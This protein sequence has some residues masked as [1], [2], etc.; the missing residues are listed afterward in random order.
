M[1]KEK[2][3]TQ[4]GEA[5]KVLGD[6][7]AGL[8]TEK[9]TEA[10]NIPKTQAEA[11]AKEKAVDGKYYLPGLS[12][13][14][15]ATLLTQEKAVK[16]KSLD[17]ARE[18]RAIRS[19]KLWAKIKDNEGN[20]KYA[21]FPQY[22]D[23]RLGFSKVQV[24]HLT[25]WLAKMETLADMRNRDIDVPESLSASAVEGLYGLDRISGL[26]LET[27]D[28]TEA[29]E[30]GLRLV[31]E[32]AQALGSLSRAT[33]STICKRRLYYQ[34]HK[35]SL[36]AQTY[37]DYLADLKT[38]EALKVEKV[39]DGVTTTEDVPRKWA[40]WTNA[41]GQPGMF[42]DNLVKQCKTDL[43]FPEDQH[44]LE[45]AT[46][47]DLKKV[48]DLLLPVAQKVI[49][50]KDAKAQAQKDREMEKALRTAL[51]LPRKGKVKPKQDEDEDQGEDQEAEQ[52]QGSAGDE[53]EED[54]AGGSHEAPKDESVATTFAC[55]NLAIKYLCQAGNTD[56]FPEDKDVI[57][58]LAKHAKAI[59]NKLIEKW[60]RE[61]PETIEEATGGEQPPQ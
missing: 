52:D 31:L 57:L 41:K 56:P 11:E 21:T 10:G 12:E 9:P 45:Y 29:E 24:T 42:E 17:H 14:E 36:K 60:E 59:V 19:Q 44:L 58:G 39:K 27:V 28:P 38:L 2:K 37:E 3:T 26:D 51:G 48:V 6:L 47:D 22:C 23:D 1:K 30:A 32:E 46:G 7:S 20:R 49:A 53:D 16:T 8:D 5:Q 13:D 54:G 55:L 4:V 40:L 35:D 18:L 15:S 50:Y 61:R 43:A 25:N 33:F 34:S